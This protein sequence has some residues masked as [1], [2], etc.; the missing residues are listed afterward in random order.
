MYF[1]IQANKEANLRTAFSMLTYSGPLIIKQ[2][3]AR[4]LQEKLAQKWE[5]FW[6]RSHGKKRQNTSIGTFKATLTMFGTSVFR[7]RFC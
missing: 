2:I 6:V 3:I 1:D 4:S 5:K 7:F